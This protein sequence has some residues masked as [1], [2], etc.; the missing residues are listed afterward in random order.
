MQKY[1][2]VY[3]WY[4]RKHKRYYVGCHWGTENDTYVCSSRWMKQAYRIRPQDFRRKIL[5]TNI[6][7]K[8]EMFNE[9]YKWLSL[10]SNDE[11][12]KKY[13]NLNN[14]NNTHWSNNE[15][16]SKTVGQKISEA[17]RGK[18]NGPRSQEVKDKIKETKRSRSYIKTPE[19][20]VNMSNAQK[21]KKQPEETKR[22]KS[23]S[24]K[25]AYAEGRKQRGNTPGYKQIRKPKVHY[26]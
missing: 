21:G 23:E 19:M 13:Y 9:E 15:E 14:K 5:K 26:T 16:I 2:F 11:L 25:L 20:L 22:K 18:S 6:E 1:G 7:T 12:G 3:I 4:D 8:Q 24:L 10:I 17:K